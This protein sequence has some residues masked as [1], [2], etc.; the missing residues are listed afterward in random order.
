MLMQATQVRLC[1]VIV[2]LVVAGCQTGEIRPVEIYEEDACSFCRMAISDHRFAGEIIVRTGEVVKF[3]D[4]GCM[5]RFSESRLTDLPAA[6]FVKDYETGGWVP[7]ATATIVK[8]G[9]A[10]PMN[11][12]LVAFA[13]PARASRCV[14]ENP[15]EE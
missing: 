2:V 11:S 4:L 5:R 8:T 6:S 12:G 7:E 1:L 13:D 3:D 9:I 15:P 14:S 10:T